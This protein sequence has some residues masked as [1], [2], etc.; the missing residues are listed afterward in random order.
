M[1]LLFVQGMRI[2]VQDGLDHRKASVAGT[3]FWI[4]VGFQNEWIFPDLLGDGF[5]GILLG[6]GMTSGAIVAVAMMVFLELTGP[7][8]RQ[9]RVDVDQYTLQRLGVFLR[10]FAANAG[11]PPGVG[12]AAGAGG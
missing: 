5:L 3:A 4:G 10:V 11:W 6:N 9:L 2:V 7:R 1:A 8:R 12:G